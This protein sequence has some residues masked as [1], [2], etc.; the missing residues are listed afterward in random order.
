MREPAIVGKLSILSELNICWP[1]IRNRYNSD[2][3]AEV[4]YASMH[5]SRFCMLSS[6]WCSAIQGRDCLVQKFRN[7]SVML[8][9]PSFRPKVKRKFAF[10]AWA[11][12]VFRYSILVRVR[13]REQRI[14][15]RDRT[16]LLRCA[17]VSK[18][19]SMLVSNAVA[20]GLSS[21][22]YTGALQVS[23]LPGLDRTFVMSNAAAG[24]STI[25]ALVLPK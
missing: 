16:I 25:V 15:S 13:S 21:P 20:A 2:K 22:T 7:S 17:A 4:S 6:L 9:H 12:K 24:R 11:L 19:R 14:S 8:E 18:M 1:D 10:L 5:S 23:L 3:V